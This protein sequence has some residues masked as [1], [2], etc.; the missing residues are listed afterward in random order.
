[1]EKSLH[2]VRIAAA[3]QWPNPTFASASASSASSASAPA[4]IAS[5]A[6]FFAANHEL[7]GTN[8]PRVLLLMDEVMNADYGMILRTLK[9][10]TSTQPWSSAPSIVFC[11]VHA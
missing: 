8:L 6:S 9:S 1:M 2:I 7:N 3:E 4:S 5:T 11:L 10:I